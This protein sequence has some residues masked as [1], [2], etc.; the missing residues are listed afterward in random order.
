MAASPHNFKVAAAAPGI[1]HTRDNSELREEEGYLPLLPRVSFREGE[2]Y[3]QK[4][5]CRVLIGQDCI[6]CPVPDQ[7]LTR[8][9]RVPTGGLDALQ[10]ARRLRRAGPLM[11]GRTHCQRPGPGARRRRSGQS[12]RLPGAQRPARGRC[13]QGQHLPR[14]W[15]GVP[16]WQGRTVASEPLCAPDPCVRPLAPHLHWTGSASSLQTSAP[17]SASA[18]AHLAQARSR[19][20]LE[21]SRPSVRP[22]PSPCT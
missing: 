4:P 19:L 10:F 15:P 16:A 6:T 14:S 21:T 22:P 7:S 11:P 2:P 1:T 5:P 17:A 18:V 8:E 13:P 12:L 9:V 3:S 20:A